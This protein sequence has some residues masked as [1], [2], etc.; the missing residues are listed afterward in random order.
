MVDLKIYWDR[1][2]C[3]SLKKFIRE[4]QIGI[5]QAGLVRIGIVPKNE[6]FGSDHNILISSDI[7]VFAINTDK[8][9]GSRQCLRF[10]TRKV[11]AIVMYS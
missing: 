10:N 2:F 4:R 7:A 6:T 9:S 3:G 11:S 1:V 8:G 5:P